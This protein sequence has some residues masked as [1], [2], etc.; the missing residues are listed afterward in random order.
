[1]GTV[2][3]DCL[4]RFVEIE[5]LFGAVLGEN[6]GHGKLCQPFALAEPSFDLHECAYQCGTIFLHGVAYAGNLGGIL[7]SFEQRD[8]GSARNRAVT[9]GVDQPGGHS[10]S[11]VEHRSRCRKR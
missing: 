7:D 11:L 2:S 10:G 3:G 5:I 9:K 8:G 4:E 1:M 6:V